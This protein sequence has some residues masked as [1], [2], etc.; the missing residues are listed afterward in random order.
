[1]TWG[2]SG[3]LLERGR[4]V[5]GVAF[6]AAACRVGQPTESRSRERAKNFGSR[7]ITLGTGWKRGSRGA[8]QVMIHASA[9]MS[10]R[11]VRMETVKPEQ[12][13]SD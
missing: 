5:E 11:M 9:L 6:V 7:Q 8:G 10:P 12:G 3:A 4:R 2:G 13:D 1:V